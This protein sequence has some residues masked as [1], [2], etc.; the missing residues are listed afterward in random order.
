MKFIIFI[1]F[2]LLN[3]IYSPLGRC[4]DP[5]NLK[6]DRKNSFHGFFRLVFTIVKVYI[7]PSLKIIF[8]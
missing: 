6:T 7:M 5:D 4:H 3:K 1:T 2:L 8:Y